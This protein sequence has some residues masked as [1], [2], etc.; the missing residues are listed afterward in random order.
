MNHL[1]GKVMKVVLSVGPYRDTGQYTT[2]FLDTNQKK[3]Q[4]TKTNTE[5][6]FKCFQLF[7]I[8]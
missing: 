2:Q 4:K 1:Y 6:V 5:L 3:K 8:E 7:L